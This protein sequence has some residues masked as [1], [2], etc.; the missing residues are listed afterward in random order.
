MTTV[1]TALDRAAL[2][3]WYRRNRQ[4]SR[5]LFDIV[6]PEAYYSR[7]ISLRHP[8]VFYE[9]HLPAFS[10][11]TL[12]K[13]GLGGPG[14]DEHLER[15]FARGI[16]PEDEASAGR[17][18]RAEWP[19]RD[20]VRA[21]RRRVRSPRPGRDCERAD[22]T[23]RASAAARSRGGLRDPR[24][25]GDAPG[26]DGLHVA[27]AAARSEA[28][29]NGGPC[30]HGR[31]EPVAGACRGAGGPRDAWRTARRDS[32]RVG[33]R[34]PGGDCRRSRV[35][36]RRPQRHERTVHGLRRRGRIR[37]AGMVDAR[38]L[39]VD[40]SGRDRAS[41]ASGPATTDRGRG[42]AC[43]TRPPCRPR[44]RSM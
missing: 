11:N 44:G 41:A 15:L 20:E 39:G 28:R 13:K 4:R 40:S 32:V 38:G 14:V 8:I 29:F 19:S 43:S 36:D 31:D 30:R 2:S 26:N 1:A 5:R 25:R 6:R 33:Q 16:D 27:S 9:G 22:R 42:A 18:Q 37:A 24:A 3:D 21:L 17:S 10:L 12:V 23:T 35:R 7:P 34:V